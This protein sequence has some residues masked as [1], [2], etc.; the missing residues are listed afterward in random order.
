MP[1]CWDLVTSRRGPRPARR[2]PS[3]G[4]GPNPVLWAR[5]PAWYPAV[6]VPTGPGVTVYT[7]LVFADR[8][9]P[10]CVTVLRKQAALL[11][12]VCNFLS[13]SHTDSFFRDERITVL[14]TD[15]LL[16]FLCCV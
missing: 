16:S 14:G 4:S 1:S 7:A 3:L 12:L 6:C 9:F 13:A 15:T 10:P 11:I 2:S 8:P 5:G